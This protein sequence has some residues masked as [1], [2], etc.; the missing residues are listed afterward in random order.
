MRVYSNFLLFDLL[1][2]KGW[3][4]IAEGI[5]SLPLIFALYVTASAIFAIFTV[6]IWKYA[7]GGTG[8]RYADIA[9]RIVMTGLFVL[10]TLICI[11]SAIMEWMKL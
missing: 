3:I 1:Q 10:M 7:E 5:T 4:M 8:S 9:F 6:L 2:K 11:V